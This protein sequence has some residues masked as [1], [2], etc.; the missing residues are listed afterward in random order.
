MSLCVHLPFTL[1][2]GTS[3]NLSVSIINYWFIWINYS[4][5]RAYFKRNSYWNEGNFSLLITANDHIH[6]CLLHGRN[7]TETNW[8]ES[9]SKGNCIHMTFM[10]IIKYCKNWFFYFELWSNKIIKFKNKKKFVLKKP[11]TT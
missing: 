8:F 9:K 7:F 4:W 1:L 2:I 5:L 6:F 10:N 3:W 11:A